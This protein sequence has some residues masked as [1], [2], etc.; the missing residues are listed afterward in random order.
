LKR[1]AAEPTRVVEVSPSSEQ[2]KRE[3]KFKPLGG[4]TSDAWNTMLAEQAMSSGWYGKGPES[5]QAQ[6]QYTAT[7]DL[8]IGVDPKDELEGMLAAQ[9]LASHNAAMECYRRAM[10]SQQTFE[11]RRE[12]LNQANKLSRTHA[13]LL[14]ALNRHRGKGQ[15]KVTVEHVHVHEGGQAIVGNVE[16]GGVRTKLENQPHALGYAPGQTLR[17]ENAEREA[18]PVTGD[19]KR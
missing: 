17:S 8:L 10:L 9:L 14:E 3:S 5:A 11:G 13:T 6:K 1:K 19:G 15:Q 18:V 7:L 12:N 4:S 16:G 2:Q